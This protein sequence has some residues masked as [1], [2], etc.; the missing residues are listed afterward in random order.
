MKHEITCNPT[1]SVVEVSLEAGER[2][3][4]DAGAMAWMTPNIKTETT[5][6]GGVFAGMKRALLSGES[7]FQNTY[8]PEGGPGTVAFAP[9]SSGDI[10]LVELDQGEL[11][12]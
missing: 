8:Y 3:V 6:R 5:T 1:Y 7:F 2:F 4:G 12:H 11:L 9:G 10:R